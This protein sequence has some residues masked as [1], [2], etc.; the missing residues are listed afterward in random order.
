MPSLR[1]L[2][3]ARVYAPEPLGLR[4][5][6]VAHGKVLALSLPGQGALTALA[7]ESLDLEGRLLVPGLVDSLTHITGG[8][9]EDGFVSRTPPMR[10]G[11]AIEAGVT[12]VAGALGTD[13]I[14]QSLNTLYAEVMRLRGLGLGAY[15]YTGSYHVPPVT[16]TGDV[17]RDLVL[18]EPVIGV[19][20]IAIADHRG[21]QPSVEELARIAADAQVGGMLAGKS[22][23]VLVHVG[24]HESGLDRLFQVAQETAVPLHRFYPTH[25]NRNRALFAQAERF[26]EAGGHVDL[27]ASTNEKLLQAGEVSC[28]E[29]LVRWLRRGLP[30]D[31]IT[32]ST[33]GHASLP[34]FNDEGGVVGL[35]VGRM[36][37]LIDALRCCVLE[38]RLPLESALAPVTSNPARILGLKTKG[39][40]AE[41][42]DA[43]MLVLE[44]ETLALHGVVLGGRVAL[45]EGERRLREAFE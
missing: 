45:W 38:A 21:S 11:D 10:L 9:G 13:R 19:G 15:L 3:N 24:P 44:P 7:E 41:G 16:L 35:E 6:L 14:G 31:R 1:I 39:R 5:V 43:D 36:S 17:Q 12:T 28:A 25:V 29:G 26:A 34:V 30:R 40:L 37:S 4:D 32:F 20:E 22:G 18:V 2:K 33:D 42:M 23:R 8:G 27:T